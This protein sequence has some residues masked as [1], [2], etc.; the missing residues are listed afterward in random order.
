MRRTYIS[1]ISWPRYVR[2]RTENSAGA[3]KVC[4]EQKVAQQE[5][6]CFY[7]CFPICKPKERNKEV[8]NNQDCAYRAPYL[9]KNLLEFISPW[10]CWKQSERLCSTAASSLTMYAVKKSLALCSKKKKRKKERKEKNI[11]RLFVPD[12][13]T[14]HRNPEECGSLLRQRQN[15]RSVVLYCGNA[16]TPNRGQPS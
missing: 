10:I 4:I 15:T 1:A 14:R 13:T 8:W 3:G 6:L 16:K 9:L 2:V 12:N 5:S 7:Q 11:K